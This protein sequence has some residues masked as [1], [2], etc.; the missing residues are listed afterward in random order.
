MFDISSNTLKFN[1]LDEGRFART[2]T[3]TDVQRCALNVARV[4]LAPTEACSPSS[5]YR[6][7]RNA[8]L[9]KGL[10]NL[11]RR[12]FSLIPRPVTFVRPAACPRANAGGMV[13][14]CPQPMAMAARDGGYAP[15]PSA[16][17]GC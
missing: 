9:L 1:N 17:D 13:S 14:G 16:E 12:H 10:C 4:S 5:Q 7:S 3:P 6:F 11:L 15:W 8:L 2:T